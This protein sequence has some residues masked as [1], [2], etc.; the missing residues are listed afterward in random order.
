MDIE[1]LKQLVALGDLDAARELLVKARRHGDTELVRSVVLTLGAQTFRQHVPE[2]G[3]PPHRV[4][5]ELDPLLEQLAARHAR[6]EAHGALQSEHI[7][8][9]K[10]ELL[11]LGEPQLETATPSDDVLALGKL[12]FEML[13]GAPWN[14]EQVRIPPPIPE[15][16]AKVIQRCLDPSQRYPD[17][18]ALRDALQYPFILGIPP[19][20]H[21]VPCLTIAV[22]PPDLLPQGPEVEVIEKRRTSSIRRFFRKIFGRD[23][24]GSTSST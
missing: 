18:H 10:G 1:R 11:E 17:A 24:D 12:L 23:D 13:T 5:A 15:G 6:G 3:L 21:P 22:P 19:H 9:W 16:L 4:L 20:L 14:T 8:W 7:F 2:H